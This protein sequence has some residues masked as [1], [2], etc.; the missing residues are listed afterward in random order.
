[1]LDGALP[2]PPPHDSAGTQGTPPRDDSLWDED[3][4]GGLSAANGIALS[5]VI[6]AAIWL[7]L[8]VAFHLLFGR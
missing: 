3:D 1:M 6:S 4:G 7:G 2:P 5:T 8:V